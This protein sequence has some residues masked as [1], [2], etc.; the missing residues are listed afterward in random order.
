MVRLVAAL[1]ERLSWVVVSGSGS[2]NGWW[3]LVA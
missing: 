3:R 1:V 2:I